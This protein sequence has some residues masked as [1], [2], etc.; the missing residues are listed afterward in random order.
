M[1][2][3]GICPHVTTQKIFAGKWT[4]LIFH[5]LTEGPCRFGELQRSISGIT[6][7]ALTKQ[8]RLLESLELINRQVFPEIPPKVEY[9]LTDMGK[10]LLP[11]MMQLQVFGDK[12]IDYL[13]NENKLD[14][15]SNCAH[16]DDW[17]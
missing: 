9:S 4:I 13:K 6:Q 16:F 17:S 12:Y 2:L 11:V 7:S 1:N 14:T 10:E 3:F 8:L 15:I 5:Y